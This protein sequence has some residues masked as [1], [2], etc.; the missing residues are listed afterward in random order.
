MFFGLEPSFRAQNDASKLILESILRYVLFDQK[1]VL[2]SG[3]TGIDLSEI[4]QYETCGS[5]NVNES[6]FSIIFRP[7]ALYPI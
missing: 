6:P 7:I 2:S 4:L 1:I 5:L 3:S